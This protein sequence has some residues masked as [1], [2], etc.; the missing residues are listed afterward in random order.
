M[1]CR[2]ALLSARSAAQFLDSDQAPLNSIMAN[3]VVD[4]LPSVT[5]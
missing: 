3:V 4:A 5:N 1:A 2:F